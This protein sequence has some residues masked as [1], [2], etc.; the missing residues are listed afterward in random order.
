MPHVAALITLNP[1]AVESLPGMT[2]ASARPMSEIARE[3]VVLR[4]VK[5]LVG[6]VNIQL[7]D[8]EQVR[9]FHVLDRDFTIADGEL[10]PT[11]KVRRAQVYKNHAKIIEG[12][13][14]GHG[15]KAA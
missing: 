1:Q 10:T 14:P 8:F 5:D 13:F 7:A 11:M 15:P 2:G 4:E 3:K 6:R 9:R 12:L